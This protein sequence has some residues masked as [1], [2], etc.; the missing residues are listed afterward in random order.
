MTVME[1]KMTA[2]LKNSPLKALVK[3]RQERAWIIIKDHPGMTSKKLEEKYKI[4]SASQLLARMVHGGTMRWQLSAVPVGRNRVREYYALGSEYEAVET[5]HGRWG[6]PKPKAAEQTAVAV[7]PAT[8]NAPLT[9]AGI[10]NEIDRL[11]LAQSKALEAYTEAGAALQAYAEAL[12]NLI[13]GL[14]L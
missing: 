6:K 14:E 2:A 7:K 3:T 9:L 12:K 1:Q 4:N 13:A 11:K 5:S 10:R 8:D